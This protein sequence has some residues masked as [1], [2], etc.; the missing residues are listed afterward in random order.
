MIKARNFLIMP[1]DNGTF[2]PGYDLLKTGTFSDR[3]S[4]GSLLR[5]FV[6]DRGTTDFSIITLNRMLGGKIPKKYNV[7][8]SGSL[9]EPTYP[10]VTTPETDFSEAFLNDQE[11]DADADVE[12]SERIKEKRIIG[13]NFKSQI[14][15]ND[16]NRSPSKP[17]NNAPATEFYVFET[18]GDESS[19]QAVFF[20][21]PNIFYGK[22][23]KPGSLVL[24]DSGLTGSNG[25]IPITL[26]DDGFGSIYR[27]NS[28]NPNKLH[29]VGNIFYDHGVVAIKSPHLFQFAS[30]SFEV[31][32]KGTQDIF[33]RE[34]LVEAPKNLLNSSSNPTFQ[35]LAPTDNANEIAD[36]FV[37]ITTVLLHD[38][39]LN[40]IGRATLSQP[41]VK[42]VTDGITFRLKK[43]F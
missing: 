5:E 37:Y 43:D 28:S 42:R 18:T 30:S 17:A 7:T 41:I 29:S 11:F 9:Y 35:K 25:K 24:K 36:E 8:P 31:S 15:D 3:P 6:N 21:I 12:L 23:I 16:N 19:S 20:N 2:A 40:V 22:R 4:T 33:N 14:Y 39:N 26:K 1:N 10:E 27:S 34:I 32:F 38:E 13:T